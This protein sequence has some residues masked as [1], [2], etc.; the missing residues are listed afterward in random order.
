MFRKIRP[1]NL[2]QK[3]GPWPCASAGI[4]S[5]EIT[6]ITDKLI[7]NMGIGN[8]P[9]K[10]ILNGFILRHGHESWDLA[11]CVNVELYWNILKCFVP[12]K[13][14]WRAFLL[15]SCIRIPKV[16]SCRRL[17]AAAIAARLRTAAIAANSESSPAEPHS[18]GETFDIILLDRKWKHFQK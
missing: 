1:L 18:Y 12:K 14:Y 4:T 3:L 7:T 13:M 2:S 17:R 5:A 10:I 8:L 16:R 9:W 15:R 11:Q 6:M